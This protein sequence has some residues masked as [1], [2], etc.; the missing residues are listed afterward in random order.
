[1][2]VAG[3][4]QSMRDFVQNGIEHFVFGVYTRNRTTEFNKPWFVTAH[5]H[6]SLAIVP[7]NHPTLLRQSVVKQTVVRHRFQFGD[8]H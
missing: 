7:S 3:T 4:H 8:I 1:M 2:T 5:T 6:L